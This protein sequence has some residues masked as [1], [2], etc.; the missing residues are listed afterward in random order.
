MYVYVLLEYLP[1]YLYYLYYLYYFT[2]SYIG[3]ICKRRRPKILSNV[4]TKSRWFYLVETKN[5]RSNFG[6][7]CPG[8]L[9]FLIRINDM[10]QA[11]KPTIWD[12]FANSKLS[13][14]CVDDKTK[15]SLFASKRRGE[16]VLKLNIRYREINI[17]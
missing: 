8:P 7:I 15:S 11:V 10:P 13:I 2:A 1:G 16:N 3:Y 17:K 6:K 9:S 4:E 5:I 12:W 14:D